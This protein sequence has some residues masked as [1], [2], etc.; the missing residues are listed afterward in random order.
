MT[1]RHAA[2]VAELFA[3]APVHADD[4][5]I[6]QNVC[7]HL[8]HARVLLGFLADE[9]PT[10]VEVGDFGGSSDDQDARRERILDEVET[11]LSEARRLEKVMRPASRMYRQRLLAQ[12]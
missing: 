5:I 1:S 4:R 11:L 7:A 9:F 6:W 2:C 3:A 8:G 12:E 10:G